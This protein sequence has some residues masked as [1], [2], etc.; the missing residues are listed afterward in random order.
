MIQN[1]LSRCLCWLH[2]HWFCCT[3]LWRGACEPAGDPHS[4]LPPADPVL[5]PWL[6][7]QPQTHRLLTSRRQ[8]RSLLFVP[9]FNAPSG[10]RF[11]QIFVGK[12]TDRCRIPAMRRRLRILGSAAA[13][14]RERQVNWPRRFLPHVAGV[15]VHHLWWLWSGLGVKAELFGDLAACRAECVFTVCLCQPGGGSCMTCRCTTKETERNH[16]KFTITEIDIKWPNY[17]S[18]YL[19]TTDQNIFLKRRI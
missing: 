13:R 8:H 7:I 11:R 16:F 10:G 5:F 14:G 4:S 6:Q 15:R 1:R 17:E 18:Q 9:F 19:F 3:W 12:L 2:T